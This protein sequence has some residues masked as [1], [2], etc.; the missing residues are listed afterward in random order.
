MST[1]ALPAAPA[2]PMQR[3]VLRR[4]GWWALLAV[5]LLGH[6]LATLWLQDNLAGD[7][8]SVV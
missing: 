3:R 2:L 1:L 8:K 6:A 7:R 5:V 4:S